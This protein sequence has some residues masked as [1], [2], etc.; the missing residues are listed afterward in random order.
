VIKDASLLVAPSVDADLRLTDPAGRRCGDGVE[1]GG[2]PDCLWLGW[3]PPDGPMQF[4]V[5]DPLVGRYRLDVR[6]LADGELFL[7]I[8]VQADGRDGCEDHRGESV[9]KGECLAWVFSVEMDPADSTCAV[10]LGEVVRGD[11]C[12]D[13]W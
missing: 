5:S 11:P 4:Q 8:A 2:W 1:S 12:G 7:E 3:L 6:P 13:G 9:R 10:R